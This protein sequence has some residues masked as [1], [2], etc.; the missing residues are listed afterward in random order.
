MHFLSVVMWFGLGS[1]RSS[2]R[3]GVDPSETGSVGGKH[4]ARV[5]FQIV[6]IEI[7]QINGGKGTVSEAGE[8]AQKKKGNYFKEGEPLS[9]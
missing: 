8:M 2:A 6:V 3:K 4:L 9:R 7:I 5:R 1:G